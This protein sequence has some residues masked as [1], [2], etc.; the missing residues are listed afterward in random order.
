MEILSSKFEAWLS[1]GATKRSV[2]VSYNAEDW[3]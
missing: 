1:L 3:N 2:I